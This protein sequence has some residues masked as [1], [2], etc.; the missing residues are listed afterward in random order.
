MAKGDVA[1]LVANIK[2]D[3]FK[4]VMK[5]FGCKYL[6]NSLPKMFIIYLH[7][8]LI[9]LKSMWESWQFMIIIHDEV[10]FPALCV[11]HAW[12]CDCNIHS[13]VFYLQSV[14]EFPLQSHVYSC[15]CV[16]MLSW[17]WCEFQHFFVSITKIRS[18]FEVMSIVRIK[19]HM[20]QNK[21]K[22]NF[23]NACHYRHYWNKCPH[24]TKLKWA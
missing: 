7:P 16:L 13:C 20:R 8:L 9:A 4:N 24:E 21:S 15:I 2:I 10:D 22:S 5:S 12:S 1:K 23:D 14:V 6:Y 3:S 19:A 11:W 17:H 18:T